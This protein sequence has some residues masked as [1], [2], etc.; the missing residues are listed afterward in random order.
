MPQWVQYIEALT[1]VGAVLLTATA[2]F[3]AFKTY[4]Q[5]KRADDRAEW[6]RRVQF[7]VGLMLSNDSAERD[8]GME[9]MNHLWGIP[10]ADPGD[11]EMIRNV[12]RVVIEGIVEKTTGSL[13]PPEEQEPR[14]SWLTKRKG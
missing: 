2:A 5:R 11:L 10:D 9:L 14:C 3:I 6:W 7:T 8:A 13:P 12:A 1:P 4:Q